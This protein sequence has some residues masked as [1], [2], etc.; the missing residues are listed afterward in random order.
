MFVHVLC[1]VSGSREVSRRPSQAGGV[2]SYA[3]SLLTWR[4]EKG[5]APATTVSCVASLTRACFYSLFRGSARPPVTFAARLHSTPLHARSA[6]QN[7]SLLFPSSPRVHTFS[8]PSFVPHHNLFMGLSSL[9]P[10]LE[11]QAG[12]VETGR[13]DS[14]GGCGCKSFEMRNTRMMMF[15]ADCHDDSCTVPVGQE[16]RTQRKAVCA[17]ERARVG[18]RRCKGE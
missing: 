3:L 17:M 14:I 9:S 7:L 13:E 1:G 2:Q 11:P 16:I 8:L 5:Q 18:A 4:P 15:R 12:R 10:P 6:M